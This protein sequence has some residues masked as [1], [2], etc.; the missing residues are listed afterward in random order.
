MALMEANGTLSIMKKSQF[1]N[2]TNQD[3]NITPKYQTS[4]QYAG[5]ELVVDGK[6]I[7]QNLKFSG[8]SEEELMRLLKH[9][10]VNDVKEVLVAMYLPD[11]T[12]YIDKKED[13][14]RKD[15]KDQDRII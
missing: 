14:E 8:T 12:L 3:L 7:H 15:L 13:R 4:S 6:L 5:T 10:G 1:Q 11:G 9:Q 2:V